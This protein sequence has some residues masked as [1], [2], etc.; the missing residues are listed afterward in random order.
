MAVRAFF[1]S[2]RLHQFN[3]INQSTREFFWWE[4]GVNGKKEGY[5]YSLLF[6][7]ANLAN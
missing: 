3:T 6:M 2:R 7:L 4:F 1:K 5:L